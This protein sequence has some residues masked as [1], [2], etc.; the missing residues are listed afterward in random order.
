MKRRLKHMSISKA[1][2][3]QMNKSCGKVK[4]VKVP[5]SKKPTAETL[6]KLDREVAAQVNANKTIIHYL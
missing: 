5:D 2:S 4:I 3:K 6:K 1:I